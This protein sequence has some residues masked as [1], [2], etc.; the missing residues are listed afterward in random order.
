MWWK[1]I[2]YSEACKVW[3]NYV[4]ICL[5]NIINDADF[6]PIFQLQIGSPHTHMTWQTI[7]V[8]ICSKESA[9]YWI[10]E[11]FPVGRDTDTISPKTILEKRNIDF[12]EDQTWEN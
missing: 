11:S 9:N 4:L 1:T 2:N 12:C 10:S 5:A 8:P 7:T 3:K 6:L